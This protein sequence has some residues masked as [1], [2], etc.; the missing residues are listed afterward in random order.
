M[1]RYHIPEEL[2]PQPHRSKEFMP[3]KDKFA[4]IQVFFEVTMHRCLSS[5]SD[6]LRNVGSTS[7]V[8]E[9]DIS[10]DLSSQD[11]SVETSKFAEF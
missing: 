8:T 2:S 10:G 3:H 11:N 1:T 9:F 6:V 7:Q 4:K 5:F